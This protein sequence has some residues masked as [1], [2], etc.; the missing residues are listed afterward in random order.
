M[1]VE[2]WVCGI[3]EVSGGG[4][5]IWK[6]GRVINGGVGGLVVW[7]GGKGFWVNFEICFW[8]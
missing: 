2:D 3:C 6:E 8:G 5:G 4:I 7:F 1:G